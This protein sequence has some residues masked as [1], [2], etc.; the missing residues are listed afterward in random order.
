VSM[1]RANQRGWGHMSGARLTARED[2]RERRRSAP[3]SRPHWIARG[4]GGRVSGHERAPKGGGYLLWR[5]GARARARARLGWIGLRGPKW[6]FSIFLEFP[7]AF[8]FYLL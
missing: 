3:T 5:A 6:D 8:L 7:I 1:D 2:A 4:R